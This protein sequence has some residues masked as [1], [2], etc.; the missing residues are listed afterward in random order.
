MTNK[1]SLS[2]PQDESVL[3]RS[4]NGEVELLLQL[5]V[6]EQY[7]SPQLRMN[8]KA[9]QSCK[10]TSTLDFDMVTYTQDDDGDWDDDSEDL[11]PV[12]I[13]SNEQMSQF[14]RKRLGTV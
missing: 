11:S 14:I 10:K 13:L 7:E 8:L 2:V 5:P 4:I 9:C 6:A 1:L 12:F 3:H